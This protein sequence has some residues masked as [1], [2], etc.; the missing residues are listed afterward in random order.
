[1]VN[2]LKAVAYPFQQARGSTLSSNEVAR[3][4]V[5]KTIGVQTTRKPKNGTNSPKP[6]RK[7]MENLSPTHHHY[8]GQFGADSVTVVC[9]K[10]PHSLC[11]GLQNKWRSGEN[12]SACQTA[13]P[14]STMIRNPPNIYAI[15]G[16]SK[17]PGK[18]TTVASINTKHSTK[19]ERKMEPT[20][21]WCVTGVYGGMKTV[22]LP[23]LPPGRGYQH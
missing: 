5:M 4:R 22:E 3:N 14:R 18:Q 13:L 11:T 23:Q 16:S 21:H 9:T 8:A 1:M 17:W 19:R 20:C 10:P 6:P 12:Y 15:T 2:K 7:A